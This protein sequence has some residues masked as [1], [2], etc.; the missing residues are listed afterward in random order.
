MTVKTLLPQ[1]ARGLLRNV[2]R[3]RHQLMMKKLKGIIHV[4]A[5]TG[6]ERDN[7]ASYGLNVLWIEP[8]P[9]VF[10][11]LKSAISSYPKQRALEY[12][13]L[14]KDGETMTL[15]ISNNDGLSSSVMDLALHQDVWPSVHFTKDIEI[16]VHKLDTIIDRERIDLANY[17]GLVLDTQGSELLVLKGAHRVLRNA[18]MVKV[19]VA[20]FEAYAGCPRPEQITTLLGVYGLREWTRTPFAQHSSGGRYYDIVYLRK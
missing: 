10:K 19:E 20:D 14:D 6:Q 13:V 3:L 17:D 15:H 9:W 18:Q 2:A 1:I 4:G 8:I 16:Q 7:Y 5:N 11:E 12:L